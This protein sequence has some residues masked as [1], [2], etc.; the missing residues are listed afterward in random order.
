MRQISSK[1]SD[2]AAGLF[3]GLFVVVLILFVISPAVHAQVKADPAPSACVPSDLNALI[4]PEGRTVHVNEV[5]EFGKQGSA[6]YKTLS[7][8]RASG[9]FD[10]RGKEEAYKTFLKEARQGNPP[11]MVNLAVS[12]L[13]GWGT[14]TNAG[15][16]LYWLNAAANRGYAPA[17]YDLGI[18]YFKGCGVREDIAEAFRFFRL[19]AD[20]GY[21]PA[22]VNLGY[23]YD[24]GLGVP[25]DHS[26]AASWYLRA[27]EAGE[28]QAQYNLADLYLYGEGVPK[29]EAAAFGWF[30]KAAFEGHA[31]AQIMVGSMLAAGRG[32]PKELSA[33]YLWIFAA[34][35]QGDD[36][37]APTLR[38][39][40]SQLTRAEIEEAKVRA[41][42]LPVAHEVAPKVALSH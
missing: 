2:S 20:S 31:G 33:A 6:A 29:D 15:A 35:L 39:L 11:A 34:T 30:Q 7:S 13:A 42:S 26:A 5:R 25:Q 23:F 1:A 27:A 21:A 16:A 3:R 36:R 12:S 8:S 4:V 28:A 38:T 32:T 41:L 19:G 37:G 10:A 17:F 9:S 40:E 24:H 18:L 14:Q 22:Q